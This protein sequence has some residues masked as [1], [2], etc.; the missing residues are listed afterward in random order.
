[1]ADI[2]ANVPEEVT[3]VA[4][5]V[6]Q[7]KVADQVRQTVHARPEGYRRAIS[8]DKR[9]QISQP[10]RIPKDICREAPWDKEGEAVRSSAQKDSQKDQE[11]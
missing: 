8:P 9:H 2:A 7:A 3:K 10:G 5:E 6:D 4:Q 1:V 11:A